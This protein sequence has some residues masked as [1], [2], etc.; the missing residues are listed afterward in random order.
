MPWMSEADVVNAMG[1]DEQD[2]ELFALPIW[3]MLEKC[4]ASKRRR[5]IVNSA[6]HQVPFIL[7][8]EVWVPLEDYSPHWPQFEEN[9][10]PRVLQA[11]AAA[12]DDTFMYY[13]TNPH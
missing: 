7:T 5:P 3:K 11:A 1:F 12:W 6:I 8:I 10:L 4:C 9:I 2:T 13:E